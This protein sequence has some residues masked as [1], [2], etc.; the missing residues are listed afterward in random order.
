MKMLD[1]K[2]AVHICWD[3]SLNGLNSSCFFLCSW[4]VDCVKIHLGG[5]SIGFET[6]TS[7]SARV[8]PLPKQISF[9]SALLID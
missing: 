5:A 3:M 7:I 8:S 4:W 1:K 6:I 9:D 2:W